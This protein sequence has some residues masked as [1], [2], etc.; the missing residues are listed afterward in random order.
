MLEETDR[1]FAADAG[2]EAYPQAA[3]VREAA[4]GLLH[5]LEAERRTY[6]AALPRLFTH[7]DFGVGNVLV[8]GD[9]VVAVLDFD[10][11]AYRERVFD[12]VYTAFWTLFRFSLAA[13]LG[14]PT[15]DDVA[16]VA[17]LMR[18]YR[19]EGSIPLAEREV[20]ALPSEMA[21]VP[22]YYVAESGYL[23]GEAYTAGPIGQTLAF[24]PHLSLARWLADNAP[25]LSSQ[26]AAA[27]S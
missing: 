25:A 16:R 13:R 2:S 4:R 22:T 5:T 21:R 3:A 23:G 12:L 14:A 26:L 8:R 19:A 6:E 15:A 24:G 27:L 20:R 18:S 11:M 1:A 10:F 17:G 9:A 7:G